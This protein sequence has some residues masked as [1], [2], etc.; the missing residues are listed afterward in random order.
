MPRKLSIALLIISCCFASAHQSN[1]LPDICDF[2]PQFTC[3]SQKAQNDDPSL[4]IIELR[5][6]RGSDIYVYSARIEPHDLERYHPNLSLC[7]SN[8]SEAQC[9][10]LDYIGNVEANPIAEENPV[11]WKEGQTKLIVI[12]TDDASIF[13]TNKKI[14]MDIILNYYPAS[15]TKIYSREVKGNIKLRIENRTETI[16]HFIWKL[17]MIGLIPVC[18]LLY[19]SITPQSNLFSKIRTYSIY[20]VANLFL[21]IT[22]WSAL[23]HP[24]PA[25]YELIAGV[26]LSIAVIMFYGND[27]VKR[28]VRQ[29]F[30]ITISL[31]L[32]NIILMFAYF[33]II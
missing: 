29:G 1:Y 22:L 20:I 2:G 4:I 32:L 27:K 26:L 18:V 16:Y 12:K 13:P 17:L 5:N 14:Y 11:L 33:A 31:T 3:I 21:V 6:E 30:V 19:P 28:Q 23:F 10:Q 7:I 9:K 25:I 24:K 15:A 8:L